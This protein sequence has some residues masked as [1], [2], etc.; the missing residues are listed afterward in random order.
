MAIGRGFEATPLMSGRRSCTSAATSNYA[1]ADRHAH[2]PS[3]LALPSRAPTRADLRRRQSRQTAAWPSSAIGCS[4][5]RSTRI[6]SRS[7][8]TAAKCS[9]MSRW[10]TSRPATRSRVRRSSSRTRSSSA[11]PA[12]T[13]R[14]A[15][16][17]TPTI[18]Q[19]GK[20]ALALLHDSGGR[21]AWQRD[22]VGCDRSAARRRRNVDDRQL[23][24]RSE[25][26]LL[27]HGQ[28]AARLLRAAIDRATTCTR[29]RSSPLDADTGKL[30]WHFQFTPHDLHDWDSNHVPVLADVTI[31]RPGAQGRDGGQSQ[32]L[33]LHARPRDRRAHSSASHTPARSGRASSD[34]MESRSC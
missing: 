14:R 16:S 31:G 9:G 17:S 5:A 20:R 34:Q 3:D 24:P 10:T 27:G 30:K 25:S 33:L 15:D 11:T 23:R 22:V 7:I 28:S 4:W 12:A 21:R 13:C 29:R 2:R 1:W 19:T 32:R 26:D 8:A 18:P 6:S